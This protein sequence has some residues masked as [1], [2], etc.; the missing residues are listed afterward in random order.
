MRVPTKFCG[1]SRDGIRLYFFDM[2]GD[3]PAPDP[4]IGEAARMNAELAK[5]S[6]AFH[7]DLYTN[8]IIPMQ[9]EN[10]KIAKSLVDK[11]IA[12]MDKQTEFAD[13][14]NKAYKTTFKPIEEKM[15]KEANE[16]DSNDNVNRRM[17][18][19]A[20]NVNQQF[21]N[22]QQQ[23]AR[24]LAR[25]GLS[26]NSSAFA[27]TNEKLSRSQAL[28]AAGAQTGAA[29]DTQDRAI[30]LRA[31]AANFGRNMP[32]TA[33]TYYSQANASGG[34]A[35]GTN[36][37]T[38]NN[39]IAGGNVMGAGF[40]S[41]GNLN[42]SAASISQNDYNSRLSAYNSQQD[43]MGS[44]IGLGITAGLGGM[45]GGWAGAASAVSGR[46]FADGGPVH[47]GTGPVSGPGGPRDDMVP[48]R[49]SDGEFVL[50]EGAVKHFGLAR[51]KKMNDVGIKNQEARGL[52]MGG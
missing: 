46:K 45:G 37:Q 28:A 16:Y 25:Y 8:E 26:P 27:A 23:N 52:T 30:A 44:L 48:A 14:Q 5:E 13:E 40:S 20:A 42:Q 49:L 36:T 38:L 11:Y 24:N 41:A 35:S 18:I 12:T 43:A 3:A 19:A 15:A 7:K 2:G 22:A 31:G 33:A 47:Q 29:F 39:T 1:F 6:F 21:S 10:Q 50:N 4:M 34:A 51:L 17:G 32:N 9:K